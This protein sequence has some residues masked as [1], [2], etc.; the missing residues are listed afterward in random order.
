MEDLLKINW[1]I[2]IF[3][4]QEQQTIFHNLEF[5]KLLARAY[6]NI[7]KVSL[8][9]KL[10]H[11]SAHNALLL[12]N[13]SV[14]Q[15]KIN[16]L[17]NDCKKLFRYCYLK[18]GYSDIAITNIIKKMQITDYE[19]FLSIGYVMYIATEFNCT[20]QPDKE[21]R[22]KAR[23]DEKKHFS[24]NRE[25]IFS[26]MVY[27]LFPALIQK[28][29]E[30]DIYTFTLLLNDINTLLGISEIN[31]KDIEKNERMQKKKWESQNC[32]YKFWKKHRNYNV[33]DLVK[34]FK[35]TYID[36]KVPSI[37][38]IKYEWLYNFKQAEKKQFND[39]P[40]PFNR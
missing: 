32:M 30:N 7:F 34:E 5:D 6:F 12:I 28:Y 10:G 39:L 40:F 16:K 14:A 18:D 24:G 35:Q 9:S 15:E 4:E 38:T 13:D 31:Q 20:I 33:N 8:F 23:R 36:K 27:F 29:R 1:N 3:S 37:K 21:I 22:K 26:A 25:Q 2:S 19:K 11:N 17:L